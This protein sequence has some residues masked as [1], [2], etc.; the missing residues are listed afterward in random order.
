MIKNYILSILFLFLFSTQLFSQLGGIKTIDPAG[1]GPNNYL[2][3]T[4]AFAALNA[5]GVAVGGVTFNVVSGG[6]FNESPLTLNITSNQPNS[7][8]PILI[9][10]AG[11]TP[12]VNIT[13]TSGVADF[14]MK[15]V[16]TDYTTIKGIMINDAGTSNTNFTEFGFYLVRASSTDG[17]QNV[18]IQNCII[19][20]SKTNSVTTSGIWQREVDVNDVAL[21][22]T[23]IAGAYLNNKFNGNILTDMATGI[24]TS[25]TS[26]AGMIDE[27]IEI[28][29]TTGNTVTV[30]GL[31]L[32][33]SAAG[34]L[35][36]SAKNLKIAN[37][38]VYSGTGNR[39]NIYGIRMLSSAVGTISINNNTVSISA[40]SAT[41]AFKAIYIVSTGTVTDVL[42]I[43][44][45]IIENCQVGQSIY[46]GG[47]NFNPIQFGTSF[48]LVNVNN[49]VI[50]N[51]VGNSPNFNGP[52]LPC[53]GINNLQW[54]FVPIQASSNTDSSYVV[55]IY[56]NQ[57]YGNTF[58]GHFAGVYSQAL[59]T[60]IYNNQI[61]NNTLFSS[62]NKLLVGV[63]IPGAS[64]PK[65]SQYIYSNTI[66]T[67]STDASSSAEVSG[68]RKYY[69]EGAVKIYDNTIDSLY[70]KN[71]DVTGILYYLSPGTFGNCITTASGTEN[72]NIYRNKI[73]SL[74][75]DGAGSA[76]NGI[77]LD[78]LAGGTF[79]ANV[80]NNFVSD[81]KAPNSTLANAV[82][83]INI[84]R[85][86]NSKVYF[87]TVKLNQTGVVDVNFGSNGV[88]VSSS[89]T[90]FDSRDNLIVNTSTPGSGSGLT[91][92]LKFT[93]TS[94]SNYYARS[95]GNSYFAGTPSVKNLI[96]YDGTNSYQTLA[97]FKT[98]VGPN[99][100][101]ISIT[102]NPVFNSI[103]DLHT[104]DASIN[105]MGITVA[106]YNTDID[107]QTRSCPPEIGADEFSLSTL[108]ITGNTSICTSATTTLTANAPSAISYSWNPG[109]LSGSS[110][111]LSPS[112][113]TV[114]TVTAYFFGG[115]S[116]TKT[117]TV[118][119]SATSS[120]SASASNSVVCPGTPVTLSG[121]GATTYSWSSGATT[122]TTVVSPTITTTYVLTGTSSCGSSSASIVITINP[123][124][125]VNALSNVS[126]ICTGQAATITASGANSYTWNTTST[127]NTIVISPTVTTSYTV[128]GTGSNGCTASYVITQ[129]VSTCTDIKV[130]SNKLFDM[131]L[132]P[133][134]TN[135][136][137]TIQLPQNSHLIIYDVV[138][139]IVLENKNTSNNLV[140]NFSEFENG[141]YFIKAINNR[142]I[143]VKRL[144]KNN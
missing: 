64:D 144:V 38:K 139:N 44:N 30:G 24:R 6:V 126:V 106:G 5:N 108:T 53:T 18:S 109:N 112:F 7:G 102:T 10:N 50:R 132:Y 60:F 100:D 91:T 119:V 57:I 41:V 137:V 49:N 97:A 22:P 118:N 26:V 95:N 101:S 11:V 110:V 27:N 131:N 67:F 29:A 47:V 73:F 99:R 120:V 88:I 68:I 9:Q 1:S 28:G 83:G 84:G 70:S 12:T 21:Q 93:S 128:T 63:F 52:P 141:V 98:A 111:T 114:Y 25:G 82:N 123:A 104:T 124:P 142:F 136:L 94:L 122:Q 36:L 43:N 76:V 16:G 39:R 2:T 20:L 121:N 59:K 37:N 72:L 15:L 46:T 92:A 127:S 71:G 129:S 62:T 33:G 32:V 113:T 74:S 19:D 40:D 133:N 134:P 140:Y 4:S 69:V 61:Y 80:H 66:K 58:K 130:E 75:S 51:N 90:A 117:I 42:N 8:N 107:L 135:G 45:N 79:T 116:E 54:N 35:S 125:N 96:F 103:T 65:F 86:I 85:F 56:N 55:K 23:T 14:C 34:I 138:G 115:C 105:N 78:W 13:G 48:G 17:C 31:G 81:L 143:I 89:V 3:F 77:N 87:N